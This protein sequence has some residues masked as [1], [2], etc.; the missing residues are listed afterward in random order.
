MHLTT[1]IFDF[2]S[3]VG[4]NDRVHPADKDVLSRVK[5]SFDLACLP[6]CFTGPLRTASVV[7]LALSPGLKERD[8]QAATLE[9]EQDYYMRRRGGNEPLPGRD[10]GG[11]LWWMSRT[12]D[13]GRW[14]TLR[15]KVAVLNIAAYHCK[16]FEDKPLLAALPSSRVSIGW[17]QDILFP[18]AL[19]GEKVV[20]CLR[21]ARYWGLAENSEPFGHSLFAPP[22]NRGGHIAKG[23]ARARINCAVAKILQDSQ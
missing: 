19:A 14:E 17:A 22:V 4:P 9:A 3:V 16:N 21:S 2:W 18:K 13:F 8:R 1:D 12:K 6:A 23:E 10:S 20:I 7:L 11:S 15:S 5:H